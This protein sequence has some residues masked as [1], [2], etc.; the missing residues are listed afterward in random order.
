MELVLKTSGRKPSQVRI[1]YPPPMSLKLKPVAI[2]A[3]G[4]LGIASTLLVYF[5]SGDTNE[6]TAYESREKMC[7]DFAQSYL[8]TIHKNEPELTDEKWKLAI[9]IE[10]EL[11]NLCLLDL[12]QESIANHNKSP[13]DK[14]KNGLQK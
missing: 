12:N 3:L 10:T 8:R 1:L 6:G 14:Y 11:Y 13:L 2:I 4:L 5:F 7:I 9:D